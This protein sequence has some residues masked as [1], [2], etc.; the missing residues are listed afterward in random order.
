MAYGEMKSARLYVS[1]RPHTVTSLTGTLSSIDYAYNL[2]AFVELWDQGYAPDF[3]TVFNLLS[4][5]ESVGIA[6]VNFGLQATIPVD[7][8]LQLE[9]LD[10][11]KSFTIG[12]SGLGRVVE[13]LISVFDPLARKQRREDLRHKHEMNISKEEHAKLDLFD[14][15]FEIAMRVLSD[16]RSNVNARWL[17]ELG[18]EQ[19]S[20]MRVLLAKEFGRAIDSL[21]D[22][23]KVIEGPT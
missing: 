6:T 22:S 21:P 16:D 17:E 12:F 20:Q 23:L 5:A 8:Q 1:D 14:K 10:F 2:A 9:L 19:A 15:R 7:A 11:G 18:P 13:A 3:D 4:S